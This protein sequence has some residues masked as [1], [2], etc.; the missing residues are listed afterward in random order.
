MHVLGERGRIVWLNGH[1]INEVWHENDWI[2][3][4]T[5]SNTFA[6]DKNQKKNIHHF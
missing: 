3:V 1:T 5:S 2:F 6:Y 4:D